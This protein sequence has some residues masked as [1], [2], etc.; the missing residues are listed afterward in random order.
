MPACCG[1]RRASSA[2]SPS[3]RRAAPARACCAAHRPASHRSGPGAGREPKGG[4]RVPISGVRPSMRLRALARNWPPSQSWNPGRAPRRSVD[5][6]R[7][8]NRRRPPARTSGSP[9]RPLVLHQSAR[10]TPTCASTGTASNALQRTRHDRSRAPTAMSNQHVA[11]DELAAP[12]HSAHAG[13]PCSIDS[14]S[15]NRA[16]ARRAPRQIGRPRVEHK[17]LG[18]SSKP[19]R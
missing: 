1:A 12:L 16:T 18:S 15:R 7:D 14:V 11:F 13:C 2:G 4:M 17:I 19:S 3:A 6:A 5:A 9:A 10:G 8:T